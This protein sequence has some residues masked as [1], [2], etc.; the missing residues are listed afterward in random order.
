[1][2]MYYWYTTVDVEAMAAPAI[3][4]PELAPEDIR[5]RYF[6]KK[7]QLNLMSEMR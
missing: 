3:F 7:L 1:M 5:Y 4:S 2:Y 6:K